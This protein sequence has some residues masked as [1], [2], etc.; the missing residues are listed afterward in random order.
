MQAE[1]LANQGYR[2]LA[3]TAAETSR[4]ADWE[5]VDHRLLGLVAMDDPAKPAARSTIERCVR[6]GISPVLI[7]GDHPATAAAIA[8]QVGVLSP[9]RDGTRGHRPAD[10][11]R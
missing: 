7:T 2:V 4:S 6:A 11:C 1:R 9:G 8:T 5:H 3:V 10:R